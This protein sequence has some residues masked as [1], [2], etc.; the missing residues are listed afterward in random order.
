MRKDLQTRFLVIVVQKDH[1]SEGSCFKAATFK[2][3]VFFRVF[4]G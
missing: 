1:A 4:R 2:K 3:F